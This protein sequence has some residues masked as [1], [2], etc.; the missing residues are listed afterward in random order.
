VAKQTTEKKEKKENRLVRYFRGVRSEM[1]KVTW[2]SRQA[3]TRLT[4]IVL[5]VTVTMSIA[6]GLIDWVFSR[7]FALL[8]G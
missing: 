1:R 2:P 8:L 3:T 4:G 6:L 5:A 7:L